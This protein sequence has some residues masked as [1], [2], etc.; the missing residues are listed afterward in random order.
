MHLRRM[1]IL[2]LLGIVLFF[3]FI[4]VCC[5]YLVYRV[6]Q[7]SQFLVRFLSSCSIHYIKWGILVSHYYFRIFFLFFPILSI[8]MYFEALLKCYTPMYCYIFLIH[9][10]VFHYKVFLFLSNY[11]F[12]ILKSFLIFLLFYSFLFLFFLV[13]L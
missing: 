1:F 12:K 11:L 7:V 13:L 2:F 4:D 6:F 3:F 5:V 9:C 10:P 8:L